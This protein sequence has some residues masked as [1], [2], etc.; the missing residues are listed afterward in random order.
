MCIYIYI[1]M[2]MCR[3]RGRDYAVSPAHIGLVEV[4]GWF[5]LHI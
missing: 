3:E 5:L 4:L 1:Y 2:Y